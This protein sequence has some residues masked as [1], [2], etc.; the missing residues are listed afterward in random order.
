MDDY[1]DLA[2][3]TAKHGDKDT[4]DRRYTNFAMGLAG[5][6]GEVVDYLKKVIFQGH[7]LDRD[8][9]CRELGDCQWYLATIATTAGIKLSEVARKNIEKLQSRYPDGFGEEKSRNRKEGA[10]TVSDTRYCKDCRDYDLPSVHSACVE[11]MGKEGKSGWK[12]KEA[13]QCE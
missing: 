5:E 1:Q 4:R 2:E 7:E 11:C 13:T 8:K 12:P 9:L 10:P 3:R 6:S